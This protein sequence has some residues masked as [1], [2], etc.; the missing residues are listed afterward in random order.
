MVAWVGLIGVRGVDLFIKIYGKNLIICLS[1]NAF[2]C[3]GCF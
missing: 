2:Y 1:F 3:G